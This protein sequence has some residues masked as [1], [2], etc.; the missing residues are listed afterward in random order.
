MQK[1]LKAKKIQPHLFLTDEIEE[2][3]KVVLKLEID[4]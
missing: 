4:F 3:L 1:E 2:Q